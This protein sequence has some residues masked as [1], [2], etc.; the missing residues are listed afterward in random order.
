MN[1]EI[2]ANSEKGNRKAMSGAIAAGCHMRNAV[3]RW[4]Y[5]ARR[6]VIAR[7][8]IEV[9]LGIK[10]ETNARRKVNVGRRRKECEKNEK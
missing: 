10:N 1:A 7:A 9:S 4:E 2:T 5:I 3:S 6:G 8:V